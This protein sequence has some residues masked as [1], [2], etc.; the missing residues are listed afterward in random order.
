MPYKDPNVYR[1]YKKNYARRRK[2]RVQALKDM[3]PCVDCEVAYPFYVM[4]WD[5]VRGEKLLDLAS[6]KTSAAWEKVLTEIAKCDLV[7]ANC[8]AARTWRRLQVTPGI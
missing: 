6:A 5:H 2:E 4:Q 1:E 8:H 3:Q 7:C